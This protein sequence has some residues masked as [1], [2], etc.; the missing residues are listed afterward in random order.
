M[1]RI[2]VIVWSRF[3]PPVLLL[4][5][6][7]KSHQDLIRPFVTWVRCR[8]KARQKVSTEATRCPKRLWK[9]LQH[10]CNEEKVLLRACKIVVTRKKCFWELAR[11]LQRGKSGFWRLQDCCKHFQKHFGRY[12]ALSK[13]FFWD[14]EPHFLSPNPHFITWETNISIESN[15]D[16]SKYTSHKYPRV[17]PR[18]LSLCREWWRYENYL[19]PPKYVVSH[20]SLSMF[21]QHGM[22]WNPNSFHVSICWIENSAYLCH[23]NLE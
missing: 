19:A 13:T 20:P 6:R 14:K 18:E 11:L 23:P 17:F 10:Y 9:C 4:S 15:Q 16:Q 3:A 12:S 7:R 8:N 22:P 5:K 21:L 2:H 1:N